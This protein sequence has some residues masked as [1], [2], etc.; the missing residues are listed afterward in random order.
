M[1]MG[2]SV[3]F[4]QIADAHIAPMDVE[5]NATIE[6]HAAPTGS[7]TILGR[8]RLT[9]LRSQVARRGA[10]LTR[11]PVKRPQVSGHVACFR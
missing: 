2:R 9:P 6:L 11:K 10:S 3:C 5:G 4:I 7:E 8:V 1:T